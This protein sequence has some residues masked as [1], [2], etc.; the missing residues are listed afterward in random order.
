MVGK[1]F[2]CCWKLGKN[3]KSN[4]QNIVQAQK[5]DPAA[6][7]DGVSSA[8]NHRDLEWFRLEWTLMIIW[9]KPCCHRQGHLP[10]DQGTPG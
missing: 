4:R 7:V 5:E 6:D 3:Q 2:S 9:Y 10:L 8:G 1:Q